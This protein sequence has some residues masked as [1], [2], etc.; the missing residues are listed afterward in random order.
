MN[1]SSKHIAIAGL[2]VAMIGLA[3][4]SSY[5]FWRRPNWL[6][7]VLGGYGTFLIALFLRGVL[8][9]DGYGW[10]FLPLLIATAPWSFLMLWLIRWIPAWFASGLL[11]N[12][13]LIVI[14]CGGLNC[15]MAFF[16]ASR[17]RHPSSSPDK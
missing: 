10:A 17:I 9:D 5:R 3:G 15:L 4:F 1:E 14:L 8:I 7:A 16:V 11:G 2:C 13:V 12:F 6:H